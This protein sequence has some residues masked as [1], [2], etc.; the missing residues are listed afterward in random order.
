MYAVNRGLSVFV[1]GV[2]G[3]CS[4]MPKTTTKKLLWLILWRAVQHISIMSEKHTGM[5]SQPG[6]VIWFYFSNVN[7]NNETCLVNYFHTSIGWESQ[8][9]AHENSALL[10]WSYFCW[11][12]ALNLSYFRYSTCH[13]FTWYVQ[14]VPHPLSSQGE[15][16]SVGVFP[17]LFHCVC[18]W[19]VS[20]SLSV[21]LWHVSQALLC[22]CVIR[23]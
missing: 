10:L 20:G 16:V 19:H 8:C 21:C 13:P 12:N 5:C 23:L 6:T 15:F 14:L 11:G 22:F 7:N 1:Q 4:N 18:M 17:I 2:G 3:Y 9:E